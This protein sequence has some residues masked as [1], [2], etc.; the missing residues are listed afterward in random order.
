[1]EGGG[2]ASGGDEWGAAG[3]KDG[4]Q[5]HENSNSKGLDSK[6]RQLDKQCNQKFNKQ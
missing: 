4:D 3:C 2:T 6:N 5:N 1:M